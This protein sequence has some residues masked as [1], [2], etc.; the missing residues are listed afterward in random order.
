M[1]ALLKPETATGIGA[2]LPSLVETTVSTVPY[3]EKPLP[4]SVPASTLNDAPESAKDAASAPWAMLTPTAAVAASVGTMTTANRFQR[5]LP[6]VWDMSR[7]PP[8]RTYI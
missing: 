3:W 2:L 1:V 7:D 4:C 5:V 8:S 6:K